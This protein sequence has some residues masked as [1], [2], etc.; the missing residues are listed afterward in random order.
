MIRI[1]EWY[2]AEEIGQNKGLRMSAKEISKGIKEREA[3]LAE[4][5]WI[6][7]RVRAGPADNQISSIN[8]TDVDSIR[9]KMAD[10]G[11]DWTESDKRP[12]SRING[13]QLIR[14]RLE[15]A[16]TREGPGLYFMDNCRASIALLPVLP[17][18]PDNAEDV[19]T[20]AEDHLYDDVRYRVLAGNN[21]FATAVK[22][23]FPT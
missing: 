14:D 15:A 6:S 8:E 5:S 19:D 7:T 23:T 20:D 4:Q 9:K 3:A 13:L 21:R 1:A 11:V 2:G 18:D 22:V 10:E 17:R 12:G 16:K